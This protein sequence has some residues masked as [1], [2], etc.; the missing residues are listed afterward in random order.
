MSFCNSGRCCLLSMSS[1]ACCPLSPSQI[2]DEFSVTVADV[3]VR[4]EGLIDSVDNI[5]GFVLF[6]VKNEIAN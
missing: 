4:I 2:R 1:T 5:S 3:Q 6:C